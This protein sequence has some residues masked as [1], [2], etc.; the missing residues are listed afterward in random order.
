VPLAIYLGTRLL[1]AAVLLLVA[2][3]Q[4][5]PE[6][7]VPGQV[8]P[9]FVDPPTYLHLIAN[10]DGQWYRL[11]VE[12]GYPRHLPVTDGAV[13]QNSWAFY[14]LFP[15]LVRLAMLTGASFGL[16]ASIVSTTC[17]A[18]VMCLLYRMLTPSCGRFAAA[19]SVLALCTYPAAL[20]LQAAYSESLAML[21]VLVALWCLREQRYGA[22]L[23][24]G[25]VLALTR[26]IVLPLALVTGVHWLARWRRRETDPFPRGE[27][28]RL[29]VV[30]VTIAASFLLWP[31]VVAVVTGRADAYFV[32]ANAWYGQDVHGWPSW[33]VVLVGG[34]DVG[35]A[36]FI[37][38]A[39]VVFGLLIARRT[40]RLW[41][42]ELRTW[43]WAYPVYL[44][45]STRPTSSIFR[46]AMLAIVPWWP[47]PEV[48]RSVTSTRERVGL[49]AL[50]AVLGL[51][52]Q[53]LWARWFFVVTP[54]S[55]G[56]P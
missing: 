2:R 10:W 33:L 27:A 19:L 43:A 54:D 39:V 52:S 26:P 50:V 14:P 30:G 11:I 15:G 42:L 46:Y 17:G 20:A 32:T 47:F 25:L 12:H 4:I 53:Y 1:G 40:T 7:F 31:A 35:L 51:L 36:A 16:A 48:G 24:T 38:L 22:L 49:A 37:G 34:G 28:L 18:V 41:G 6:T 21:I 9:T 3:D 13:Q 44:L 56:F 8:V 29:A 5:P 55:R 23:A 45:G